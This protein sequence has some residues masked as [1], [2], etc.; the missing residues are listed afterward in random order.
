MIGTYSTNFGNADAFGHMLRAQGLDATYT[1]L[2]FGCAT[3]VSGQ[4]RRDPAAKSPA[5]VPPAITPSGHRLL[6]L[7]RVLI[8]RFGFFQP[9]RCSGIAHEFGYFQGGSGLRQVGGQPLPP[10]QMKKG[11]V[12]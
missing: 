5:F 11:L 10:H 7:H 8:D 4:N 12:A 3:A 6:R 2:F 1:E 9:I